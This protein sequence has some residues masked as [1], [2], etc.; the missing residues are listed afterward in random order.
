MQRTLTGPPW[1]M[2]DFTTGECGSITLCQRGPGG[3]R[4]EE[5]GPT[6]LLSS[7]ILRN[8]AFSLA[9]GKEEYTHQP[10]SAAVQARAAHTGSVKRPGPAKA[11]GP[12]RAGT[13]AAQGV[14]FPVGAVRQ[15]PHLCPG[16]KTSIIG[17]EAAGWL[18]VQACPPSAGQRSLLRVGPGD[19]N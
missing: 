4:G 12:L 3:V 11:S 18:G 15:P 6:H 14:P 5:G 2:R 1:S 19:C 7:S 9:T 17:A 8:G 16:R 13:R 10:S